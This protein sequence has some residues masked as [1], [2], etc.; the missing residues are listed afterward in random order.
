MKNNCK[1]CW[2]LSALLLVVV[3]G[4]IYM[5]VIRGNV[6]PSDDGRTTITLSVAERDM[7]LGEM[8]GFLESIQAITAGVVEK[9]MAAVAA[10][11][12]KVGMINAEGVPV[13]LMSKLPIAFKQL[14][15]ATHKAFDMLGVEAEDMGDEKEILS[16]L[17]ELMLNCTACHAAFRFDVEKEQ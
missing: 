13:A 9:D 14:G 4:A 3:A 5:F 15:M 17:S 6:T 12:H 7:V 8:R 1:F 2:G 16:Q 11:A 10:S